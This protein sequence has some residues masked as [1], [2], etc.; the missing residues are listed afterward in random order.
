MVLKVPGSFYLRFV[1]QH[2]TWSPLL[3]LTHTH[4]AVIFDALFLQLVNIHKWCMHPPSPPLPPLP[5]AALLLSDSSGRCGT[6]RM[7]A[8]LLLLLLLCPAVSHPPIVSGAS[9]CYVKAHGICAPP[10]HTHTHPT[11]P[12]SCTIPLAPAC[13]MMHRWT[14]CSCSCLYNNNHINGLH[15]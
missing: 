7:D 12:P 3:L 11:P 13:S 1:P 14:L 6:R 4:T 2:S 10:S 5:S 8:A 15:L 9:C